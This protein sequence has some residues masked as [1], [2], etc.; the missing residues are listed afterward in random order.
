MVGIEV[1]E[2]H[3]SPVRDSKQFIDARP[4]LALLNL[5]VPLPQRLNDDAG[6]ILAR[7]ARIACTS[8]WASDPAL[9]LKRAVAEQLEAA[10]ARASPT[11]QRAIL[12]NTITYNSQVYDIVSFFWR[13][14]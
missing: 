3:R 12:Y 5:L 13:V 2:V 8:R 1:L 4:A 10:K 9:D 14:A 6:H 7:G 11:I